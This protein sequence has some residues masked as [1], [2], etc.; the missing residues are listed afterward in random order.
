V[1]EAMHAANAWHAALCVLADY[2]PM[3]YWRMANGAE[4]WW[5]IS[6]RSEL[7]SD[8]FAG[9]PFHYSEIVSAIVFREVRLGDEVLA[10]DW[11]AVY[12]ELSAVGGLRV[13]AVSGLFIP[14]ASPPNEALRLSVY[15]T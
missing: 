12:R 10:C 9:E 3:T 15:A 14:P 4:F 7:L 5:S 2:S 1:Q 8:R 6:D 11:E 13:E